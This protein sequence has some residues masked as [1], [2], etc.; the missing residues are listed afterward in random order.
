MDRFNDLIKI[1]DE[2]LSQYT[3][4]TNS[5][6]ETKLKTLSKDQRQ[7]LYRSNIQAKNYGSITELKGKDMDS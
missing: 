3:F 4:S 2:Y 1:I 6:K 5:I 7:D